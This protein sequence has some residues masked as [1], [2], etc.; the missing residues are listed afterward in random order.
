MASKHGKEEW[1]SVTAQ[2]RF[3]GSMDG[4]SL[5]HAIHVPMGPLLVEI[6][7]RVENGGKVESQ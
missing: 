6:S 4:S 2:V 1:S 3:H 5:A 7:F